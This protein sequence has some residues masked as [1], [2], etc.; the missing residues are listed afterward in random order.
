[1]LLPFSQRRRVAA[2]TLTPKRAVHTAP[3]VTREKSEEQLNESTLM[4][5]SSVSSTTSTYRKALERY[6]RIYCMVASIATENNK[7][8]NQAMENA[9]WTGIIAA[10]PQIT[11]FP[12][13]NQE[14]S[15]IV[16]YART[17]SLASLFLQVPHVRAI[18]HGAVCAIWLR[19]DT[20]SGVVSLGESS[21]RLTT[22]PLFLP[23]N[24]LWDKRLNSWKPLRG[25]PC[26][27]QTTD[28]YVCDHPSSAEEKWML[29]T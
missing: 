14:T 15:D 5:D 6:V 16:T 21:F 19:G 29:F 22:R 18:I 25:L 1:M 20:T 26:T 7:E 3:H 17:P 23:L 24:D 2:G 28:Y 11:T 12:F 27:D 13:C 8:R 10:N 4:F 9:L